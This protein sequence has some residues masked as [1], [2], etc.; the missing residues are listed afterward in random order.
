[1]F[2]LVIKR[3]E[4]KTIFKRIRIVQSGGV[5]QWLPKNNIGNMTQ[6][7]IRHTNITIQALFQSIV[8]VQRLALVYY[9]IRCVIFTL[10]CIMYMQANK[11]LFLTNTCQN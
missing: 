8:Q 3:H 2:N 4:I 6:N 9:A 10:V 1:M 7:T 11:K 5:T